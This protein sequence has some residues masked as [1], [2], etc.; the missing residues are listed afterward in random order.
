VS[1]SSESY[2]QLIEFQ[3]ARIA[4]LE[5]TI[6]RLQID[7]YLNSCKASNSVVNAQEETLN[8]INNKLFNS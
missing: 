6:R 5:A 2:D 7:S 8:F 1:L 4:A 3:E